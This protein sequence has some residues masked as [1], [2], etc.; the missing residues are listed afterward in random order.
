MPK[1]P[2]SLLT[3]PL[4]IRGRLDCS[5]PQA[6]QVRGSD[7]MAR[8]QK[9]SLRRPTESYEPWDKECTHTP[10]VKVVAPEC[11]SD[12]G[13]KK[14]RHACDPHPDPQLVWAGRAE[15]MSFELPTVPFHVHQSIAPHSIIR[16][17]W[18]RNGEAEI[19]D[20]R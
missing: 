2:L 9:T 1:E 10:L 6:L 8:E 16:A 3:E 13:Q 18:K 11:D 19:G 4:G 12:A 17:T 5:C 20:K 7:V 14:I 15:H